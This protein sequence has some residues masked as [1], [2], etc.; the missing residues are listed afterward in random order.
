MLMPIGHSEPF[1]FTRME[2]GNLRPIKEST[3][4]IICESCGEYIDEPSNEDDA[5]N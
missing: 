3:L 2:S 5:E 4:R 1:A